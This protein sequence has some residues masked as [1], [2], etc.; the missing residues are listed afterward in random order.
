MD[1]FEGFKTSA[2][3]VTAHVVGTVR[4]LESTVEP[5]DLTELLQS[6]DKILMDEQESGFLRWNLLLVNML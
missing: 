3:E 4:E 2:E 5:E 1:D 6:H